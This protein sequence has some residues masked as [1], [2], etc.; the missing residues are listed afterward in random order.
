MTRRADV[1]VGVTALFFA[2]AGAMVWVAFNHA[3]HP[4]EQQ[5]IKHIS[6]ATFGCQSLDTANQIG[7]LIGEHDRAA[8]LQLEQQ[9]FANGDCANLD[10]GTAVYIEEVK[11]DGLIRVRPQG[12]TLAYWTVSNAVGQ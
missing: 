7:K 3:R 8:E 12:S 9:G 10:V 5:A 1:I 11:L 4:A 6:A 2:A